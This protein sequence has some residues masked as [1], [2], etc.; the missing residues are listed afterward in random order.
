MQS[1]VEGNMEK[2]LEVRF[3][4]SECSTGPVHG[5][6][7][8]SL[9]LDE[10]GAPVVVAH[11]RGTDAGVIHQGL[12]CMAWLV[13]HQA[14]FRHL[15]RDRLGPAVAAQVLWSAPRLICIVGGFTRDVH[16]VREHRRCKHR[17]GALPFWAPNRSSTGRTKRLRNFACPPRG[18][19]LLVHLKADAGEVE[20]IPGHPGCDGACTPRH[21]RPGSAE[22]DVERTV[23]L[24]RVSYA[25]V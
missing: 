16:T 24:F 9:G 8:D 5:G 18:K 12:Y 17:P 15:V 6:R 25:A 1:I 23:D 10:N 2:L 11:K 14:E 7:I 13:H 3:L 20:L 21:G 22:R 19:K 4:A